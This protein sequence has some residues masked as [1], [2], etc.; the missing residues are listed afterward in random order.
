MVMFI[1]T[2]LV[3]TKHA[4]QR[5][6][7]GNLKELKALM[8]KRVVKETPIDDSVFKPT[9]MGASAWTY[10]EKKKARTFKL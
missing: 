4:Y 8:E 5:E 3:D 2:K 9:K 1:N 7:K 10:E 6:A